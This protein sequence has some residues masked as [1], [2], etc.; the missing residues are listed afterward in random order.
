MPVNVRSLA[1]IRDFRAHLLRFVEELEGALQTMLMELQRGTE[2]IEHDRP[3]YWTSQ[4]RKAYDAVAS[5]RTA[6]NTCQMRT[7]AGRKSS[8]IEEKVAWDRAKRRLAHC[9]EQIE[10]VKR[11]LVKLNHEGDEFRGRLA[12]LRRLLDADIPQAL[13]R[14]ERTVEILE[15]YAEMAPPPPGDGP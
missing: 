9:Q 4:T 13:A 6:F 5:T 14:L 8:C 10:N 15:K 12:G 7:V 2:W 1:E 11:W 3:H